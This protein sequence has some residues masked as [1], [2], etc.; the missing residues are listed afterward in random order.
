MS[1]GLISSCS[2]P[3]AEGE[4]IHLT[5]NDLRAQMFALYGIEVG[6]KVWCLPCLAR[7]TTSIPPKVPSLRL[8]EGFPKGVSMSISSMFLRLLIE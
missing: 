4:R 7:K 1:K 5:P 3:T 6:V 8:S 2:D